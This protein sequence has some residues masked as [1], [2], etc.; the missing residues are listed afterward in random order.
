M[1]KARSA[2]DMVG[3]LRFAHPTIPAAHS[4]AEIYSP[5]IIPA[6]IS[7]RLNLRASAPFLQA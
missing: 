2:N 7:R 3:T 1:F 5:L 4:A 6:S